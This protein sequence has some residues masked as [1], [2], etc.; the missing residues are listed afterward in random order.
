[1]VLG[2]L[3]CP[4]KAKARPKEKAR[5]R[6]KAKEREK[7]KEKVTGKEKVN[8]RKET[9]VGALHQKES[10]GDLRLEKKTRG[11]A[12]Y[13]SEDSASGVTSVTTITH[14][15]ANSSRQATAVKG[16]TALILTSKRRTSREPL[17]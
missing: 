1:M 17:Q 14:N 4:P 5:A 8:K 2:F 3:E 9:K 13:G 12:D 16:R 6:A 15:L 10:V 11:P 7:E